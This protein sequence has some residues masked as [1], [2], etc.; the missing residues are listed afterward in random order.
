[1]VVHCYLFCAGGTC[2]QVRLFRNSVMN[3]AH[4]IVPNRC[5][6]FYI[7]LTVHLDVI[8]VN[9]QLHELFSMYLF[10][11]ST[12]FEQQLLIIGTKDSHPLERVIPDD[13]LTQFDPPDDENLSLETCRGVK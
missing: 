4:F 8:L 3:F 6:S 1:M 11:T 9:D 10:H 5:V 2:V 7:L 13:V 12:C